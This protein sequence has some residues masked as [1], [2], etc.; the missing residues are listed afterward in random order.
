MNKKGFTLIELIAAI[1]ILGLLFAFVIP[2]VGR[3]FSKTK[4]DQYD[5]MVTTIE[6]AAKNYVNDNSEL[7]YGSDTDN[8]LIK[9]VRNNNTCVITSVTLDTLIQ[10]DYLKEGIID[11]KTST[12]FDTSKAVD[13]YN[14]NGIGEFKFNEELGEYTPCNYNGNTTNNYVWYSG[15]LWRIIGI[16][17]DNTIKIIM[18]DNLTISNYASSDTVNYNSSYVYNYL[19]DYFYPMLNSTNLITAGDYCISKRSD[20]SSKTT[21]CDNNIN[22]K[23][24]LLSLDEYNYITNE[25]GNFLNTTTNFYTLTPKDDANMYTISNNGGIDTKT[26]DTFIGIRPVLTLKTDTEIIKGTGD[27]NNPY[28]LNESNNI[29]ISNKISTRYVGEYIS[30][31]NNTYRIVEPTTDYVKIVLSNYYKKPGGVDGYYEFSTSSNNVISPT[32]GIGYTLNNDVYND[33]FNTSTLKNLTMKNNYALGTYLNKDLDVLTTTLNGISTVNMNVSLLRIGD[34][35]SGSN[36]V[37]TTTTTENN[38]IV[39]IDDVKNIIEIP[40][41]DVQKVYPVVSIKPNITIKAGTGTYLD[42]YTL[43]F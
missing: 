31:N 23:I 37:L 27:Y 12:P 42:P 43:Q 13:V 17:K 5:L 4:D 22:S 19:N 35:L 39:T 3:I 16:T 10:N 21:D 30:I 33:L 29:A 2:S 9:K 15:F 8:T 38:N 24:G 34:I 7:F 1:T 6:N 26:V 14:N 40:T 11:P 32:E 28:I 41:T 25:N 36:A 18:Q 20:I